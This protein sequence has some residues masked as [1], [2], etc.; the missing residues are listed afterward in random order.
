MD[1]TTFFLTW[2]QSEFEHDELYAFLQSIKPVVWARV[3]RELHDDGSPHFHAIVRYG[4]RVKTRSNMAIFDYN[5]RH[6]N[7]QVPRRIHDVLEY[8]VKGGNYKDYGDV[9]QK[10]KRGDKSALYDECRAAAE[11]HDRDALDRCAIAGGLSKQWADHLWAR[12]GN[13]CTG[14]ITEPGRGVMCM[15][16]QQLPYVGGSTVVVGPAGCGKTTWATVHCPKP[17][18]WVRHVDDLRRLSAEHKSIIF[19]DMDFNHWPRTAQI[20]LVDQEF[21]SS[22]NVRYGTATIPAGL[23]R[24]FTANNPPFLS[25]PSIDRRIHMHTIYSYAL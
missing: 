16:L 3:A 24:I 18:L 21:D 15:Q 7:I 8:L 9:P 12:H 17:A 13:R 4:A 5:G 23:D 20:H 19:D 1:A 2:P 25:D 10:A 22:I 14:V 11:S 6:P